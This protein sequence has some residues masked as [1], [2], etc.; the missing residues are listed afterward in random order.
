MEKEMHFIDSLVRMPVAA[1]PGYVVGALFDSVEPLLGACVHGALVDRGK[2]HLPRLVFEGAGMR[3]DH[4]DVVL[5]ELLLHVCLDLLRGLLILPPSI[6]AGETVELVHAVRAADDDVLFAVQGK[7]FAVLCKEQIGIPVL[8][9]HLAAV[10]VR[11]AVSGN[12]PRPHF[13]IAV[14]AEDFRGQ[15]RQRLFHG[16]VPMIAIIVCADVAEQDD[17]ILLCQLMLFTKLLHVPR[18]TVNV[19]GKIHHFFS[20]FLLLCP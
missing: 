17:D 6:S 9:P 5:A 2:E 15:L 20:R 14:D 7:D 1:E 18:V 13:V 11:Q 8:Q 16:V 3:Q 12:V 4:V 19:P 10:P